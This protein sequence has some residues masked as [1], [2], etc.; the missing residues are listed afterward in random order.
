M[1][2]RSPECVMSLSRYHVA[3]LLPVVVRCL[4]QEYEHMRC[5]NIFNM[6]LA[7]AFI[8]F[9]TQVFCLQ[10]PRRL[11]W[12]LPRPGNAMDS[13]FI[14]ERRRPEANTRHSVHI[15]P[16]LLDIIC[17]PKAKYRFWKISRHSAPIQHMAHHLFDLLCV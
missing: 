2:H 14:P 7:S 16:S 15:T 10:H 13:C 11:P 9:L 3:F 6:L 5:L 8:L 17:T 12:F 4:F 1:R